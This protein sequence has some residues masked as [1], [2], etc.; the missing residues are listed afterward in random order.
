MLK[1]IRLFVKRDRLRK[2]DSVIK[3][4][5]RVQLQGSQY[6]CLDTFLTWYSERHGE[7]TPDQLIEIQLGLENGERYKLLDEIQLWVT[8]HKGRQGT[9]RVK[10]SQ[11]RSFFSHNRAELPRDPGFRIISDVPSV[12]GSLTPE[13]IKRILLTSNKLYRAVFISMFQAGLDGEMFVYWNEN[14]WNELREQLIKG[15]N[16]IKINLPGRKLNRN[17][18]PY[19]SYITTD[20]IKAIRDYL[21]DPLPLDRDFIF[22]NQAGTGI[23]KQTLRSYFRRHLKKL[24]MIKQYDTGN[25]QVQV[26]YGKNP[27]EMRDTFRTLWSMSPARYEVGEYFMGHT[28]DKLGY[29]KSSLDSDFYRREYLKASRFLNLLS[30]NAPYGLVESDEVE[31]L[32]LEVNRLESEKT[33]ELTAMKT[34]LESEIAEM[35]KQQEELMKLLYENL[36]RKN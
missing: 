6:S 25:K 3:W 17:I 2:Y 16:P 1:N 14:G 13:E 30:S 5:N 26:R 7:T 21:P 9:K 33:D 18:K 31:D 35:K 32:R 24:G 11:L 15:S 10:Y 28:V 19:Y 8:S 23:S 34:K 4:G 12:V 29:D 27:H 20:A 36:P 22:I